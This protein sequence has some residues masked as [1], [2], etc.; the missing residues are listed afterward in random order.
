MLVASLCVIYG[1]VMALLARR[2]LKRHEPQRIQTV[3]VRVSAI[4]LPALLVL[5]VVQSWIRIGWVAGAIFA[6]FAILGIAIGRMLWKLERLARH[7]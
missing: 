6:P 5:V 7:E 2:A 4:F 1:V 3:M